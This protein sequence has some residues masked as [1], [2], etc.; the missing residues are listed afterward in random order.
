MTMP[1]SAMPRCVRATANSGLFCKAQAMAVSNV[2]T[3]PSISCRGTGGFAQAGV[4]AVIAKRTRLAKRTKGFLKSG[5]TLKI[6]DMVSPVLGRARS[7]NV[8]TTRPWHLSFLSS[9]FAKN[10]SNC[11]S[12]RF[13]VRSA[14]LPKSPR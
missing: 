10:S 12:S 13:A 4:A 8:G 7:K 2:N 11:A 5:K 14:L 3:C 9:H 6:G 1:L